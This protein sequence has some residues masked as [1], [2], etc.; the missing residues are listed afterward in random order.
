MYLVS[1]DDNGQMGILDFVDLKVGKEYTIV[2][3]LYKE[4]GF[5]K[6]DESRERHKFVIL[7]ADKWGNRPRTFEYAPGILNIDRG[8][9][10]GN[11]V[12][13]PGNQFI[14]FERYTD[15]KQDPYISILEVTAIHED[16]DVVL[17]ERFRYSQ[18]GK[19]I[20]DHR[21]G[22]VLRLGMKLLDEET[23]D[24]NYRSLYRQ[25]ENVGF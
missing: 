2:D 25:L 14:V 16:I 18:Y 24:P 11:V 19:Y 5:L 6:V 22:P 12:M 4:R 3:V 10:I 15:K 17:K 8:E 23:V 20:S 7:I 9:I 13:T 21:C 1:N